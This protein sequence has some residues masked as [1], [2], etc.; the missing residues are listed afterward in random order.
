M[1]KIYVDEMPKEPYHCPFSV[2]GNY[3]HG[4]PGVNLHYEYTCVLY[5]G[6]FCDLYEGKPC[7]HL[8]ERP[9]GDKDNGSSEDK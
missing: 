4:R 9:K 3:I 1:S 2:M 6:G 8:T 5:K 7:D